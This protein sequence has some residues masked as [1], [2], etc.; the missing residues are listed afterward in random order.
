M[1]TILHDLFGVKKLDCPDWLPDSLQY[2]T[3]MGSHAYGCATPQSDYDYYGFAVPPRQYTYPHEWGYIQ[4]FDS[5]PN[6]EK[7]D[8]KVPDAVD[9]DIFGI[10]R[11]LKLL[12]DGNPN[13]VESLF[14]SEDSIVH[15]TKLGRRVRELRKIFLSK[16]SFYKTKKY[17]ESQMKRLGR[18]PEGKRVTLYEKYGFDTK[19]AGHCLRL[20][21]NCEQILATGDIDLRKDADMVI[22][23]RNGG[24]SLDQVKNYFDAKLLTLEKLVVESKLPNESNPNKVRKLLL[25]C[26]DEHYGTK[27]E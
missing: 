6:F 4:G 11:Y 20:M 7:W 9:V 10:V 27:W 13:I 8:K 22:E 18:K 21:N 16:Q 5:I 12:S 17:A 26:L 15:I 2:V 25:D 1:K 3:V 23:I 14:T 19:A 24:W